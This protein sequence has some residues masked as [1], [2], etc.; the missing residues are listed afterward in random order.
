M[1]FIVHFVDHIVEFLFLL[2]D[3]DLWAVEAHV[4]TFDGVELGSTHGALK[5]CLTPFVDA[6]KTKLMVASVNSNK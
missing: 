5:L 6:W 4:S 1:N 2:V 3:L